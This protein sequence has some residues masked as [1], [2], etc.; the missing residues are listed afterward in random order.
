MD[1]LV[2]FVAGGLS[3]AQSAVAIND[4]FGTSFSRSAA[5]GRANR[6][7]IQ[8]PVKP[9][10]DFKTPPKKREYKPRLRVAQSN[11]NSNAQPV[12]ITH[13]PIEQVQLQCVEIVPRHLSLMDLEPS[14]CRFPY[15]DN[16][17]TFC[18]HPK[19]SG[20][21]YCAPHFHLSRRR[22]LEI[23][24]AERQRRRVALVANMRRKVLGAA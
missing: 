16:A 12:F 14:D 2:A 22:S 19:L 21:N 9:K 11:T 10:S 15:G 7:G 23:D 3:Y 24:E 1:A 8:F 6:L 18:G 20:T 17:I 4:K 13:E 5:I